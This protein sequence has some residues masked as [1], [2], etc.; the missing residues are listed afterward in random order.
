ME[1][2]RMRRF[3]DARA[4]ED[5]FHFVDNR[6]PYKDADPDRFWREGERDLDTLL[7]SVDVTVRPEDVVL[8]LGCGVGRLTR[9]LAARAAH[10][11][12]L[13]V[14]P[15]M[16]RRA[17]ELNDGLGNVTWLLG[18]G[19]S[20]TGVEDASLDGAV[21]H[22]VFQHIPDPKVTL[23]YVE[24]LARVLKPGGWAAFGL[25]TDPE[26]HRPPPPERRGSSRRE[27]LRAV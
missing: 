16:L 14:S 24:E 15:E 27:L 5:A 19:E 20:L 26:V 8:D 21:S 13:D 17:Q 7:S 6:E 25:S 11:I 1:A 2:S 10:V 22:V 9:V 12:A 18:D 3:W 4:R 23:G